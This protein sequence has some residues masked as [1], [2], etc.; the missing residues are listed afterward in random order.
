MDSDQNGKPPKEVVDRVL[1]SFLIFRL[2]P[3]LEPLLA[4]QSDSSCWSECLTT[5][6]EGL[7]SVTNAAGLPFF[8]VQSS[9]AQRIFDRFHAAELIRS[10]KH[11]PSNEGLS[12]EIKRANAFS[13]ATK[14]MKEFV[15]SSEGGDYMRDAVVYDL[16]GRL[17][18]SDVSDASQELLVQTLIS[19]WSVFENFSR[20]FIVSWVDADA[21]RAS[22]VLKAPGL[23]D[24]LGKQIVDFQTISQHG[25]NLT[26]SMGA[27]LFASKRLDNLK[28]IKDVMKALFNDS[29]IQSAFG[30]ELWLLN[31]R[32]NLFVH[33]RG[34]VDKQYLENTNASNSLGEKLDLSCDDIEESLLSVRGAMISILSAVSPS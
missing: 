15:L 16:F 19:T 12:D 5:A 9:V 3:F 33:K 26:N 32:R 4:Y 25:F 17:E 18:S 13:N 28:V 24:I 31:Q 23:K 7:R 14:E 27:V 34:F 20:S 29:Q 1:G 30:D 22:L 2:E 10:L 21:S 6:T 11:I 8:L